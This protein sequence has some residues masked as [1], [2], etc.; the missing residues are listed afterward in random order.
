MNSL[1]HIN[2]LF[3]K[4]A[5][6]IESLAGM[7]KDILIFLD[8]KTELI[9]SNEALSNVIE[10]DSIEVLKQKFEYDILINSTQTVDC[11]EP[12]W[13][14]KYLKHEN[15]SLRIHKSQT[16]TV[17]FKLTINR[18]VIDDTVVYMLL[19]EDDS[20][21]VKA[22]RAHHYFETFKRKFLTSISHE[23]RTPM[24]GIL[25][26][27]K[28]LSHSSM[29]NTQAHQLEMV[30]QSATEMMQKIENLLEMMQLESGAI[31]LKETVFEPHARMDEFFL[32]FYEQAQRKNITF[33]SVIDP[34]IPYSMIGDSGKIK[35]VLESLIAN[36][37][38]FT[39]EGG[40]VLIEIKVI[41]QKD[42]YA[43]LQYNVLDSG[44][45]IAKEKLAHILRPFASAQENQK[46]GKHGLGIGLSV[47]HKY[48]AMM[49][50]KLS[51]ASS[52]GKGSKFFFNLKH[53]V[54][55]V[56]QFTKFAN[57]KAAV[58]SFSAA[59]YLYAKCVTN[60]LEDFGV[61]VTQTN[62]IIKEELQ[63]ID[64]LFLIT[65]NLIDERIASVRKLLGDEVKIVSILTKPRKGVSISSVKNI[66]QTLEFPMLPS[67]I[68]DVLNHIYFN[69]S[70]QRINLKKDQEY[71]KTAK[72]L[73]AEDNRINLELLQ[74]ILSLQD[75]EV[76]AV[77]NG[78]L[79]VEAYMKSSFDLFLTDIDM[80][81]M[82][83]IVATRLIRE[84][85]KKQHRKRI[86]VIALTAYALEGDRERIMNAGLDAHIPKPVDK[87]YLLE[88]IKHFLKNSTKG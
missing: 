64:A 61:N 7:H 57:A 39:S 69:K 68:E 6:L 8:E 1:T 16:Q 75:Y 32:K 55:E 46:L 15:L 27:V 5:S 14:E 51:V 62:Q 72:I 37:I 81:V 84:V 67:K 58:V 83:G 22:I 65:E 18:A 17:E 9:G 77:E 23:F 88:A 59:D 42:G 43:E 48:L 56:S 24:N 70:V 36:A 19:L 53:K 60:Y 13:I 38:K 82:D 80:P 50:S 25:G 10:Y 76:T 66:L 41:S 33:L 35:R 11:S 26:F 2:N 86:P 30:E 71:E 4:H 79:A 20:N 47:S 85:D 63:N 34:Q 12:K 40:Q 28:L 3:P 87:A 52:I 44:A 74:T 49:N 73:L 78:E 29:N 31:T 54:N 21:V 45:G